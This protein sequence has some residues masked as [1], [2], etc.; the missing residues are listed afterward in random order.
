MEMTVTLG[1]LVIQ[2]TIIRETK[3]KPTVWFGKR[4]VAVPECIAAGGFK[5]LIEAG[6]PKSCIPVFKQSSSKS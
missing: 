3:L 1:V 5:H 6:G 4:Q 2:V